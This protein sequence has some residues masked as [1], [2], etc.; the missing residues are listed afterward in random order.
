MDSIF[1]R[2]SFRAPEPEPLTVDG[3]QVDEVDGLFYLLLWN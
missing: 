1:Q 2:Y 3:E